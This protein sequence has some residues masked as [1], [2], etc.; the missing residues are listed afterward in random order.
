MVAEFHDTGRFARAAAQVI[1]FRATDDAA[2][3][4]LD[5]F[6]VRRIKREN[7]LYAFAERNLAHG[8][9]GADA[10]VRTRNAHALVILDA[11]A[12]ALDNLHADA[13]R[14]AGTELG[15]L[16]RFVERSEE[17]TSEIQSLMRI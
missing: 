13:Q 1:K 2:T 16:F 7:A 12:L 3:D 4:D 8:E 11:G 5:H 15:N 6:K 9:A 14:V 10:L 17:H